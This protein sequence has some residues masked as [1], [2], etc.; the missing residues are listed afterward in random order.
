MS[1]A[2]SIATPPPRPNAA[3]MAEVRKLVTINAIAPNNAISPGSDANIYTCLPFTMAVQLE[4]KALA[5][6]HV[7]D[8]AVTLFYRLPVSVV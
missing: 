3:L 2:I 7:G 1:N 8:D 6:G 5:H 4:I